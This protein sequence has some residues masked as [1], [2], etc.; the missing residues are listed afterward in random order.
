MESRLDAD[1]DVVVVG[2]GV[3]GL[4]AARALV[5]AGATVVVVEA[6]DRVG[7]RLKSVEAGG[8]VG[9][10]LGA[11][12]F[13]PGEARVERLVD[14]FSLEV[15][16]QHL[17][18]DA[19][20]HQPG[21]MTRIDGNPIDVPAGRFVRG[22]VAVTDALARSLPPGVV[23]C[24]HPV[25]AVRVIDG[26]DRLEV[27]S[28]D[29]AW[30]ACHVILALAP[31]LAAATIEFDPPLPASLDGLARSTPVWMGAMTKVVVTYRAPF[32]R[33]AGLAGAGISHLGPL[34]E[35]HDMSGPDGRPAALF[36]F[37]PS[38]ALRPGAGGRAA[39]VD[40]LVRMFGPPA[41]DPTEVIIADWSAEP[42]TSPPAVE[43][44]TDYRTYGHPDFA[45]PALGGRLHWSS[46]ETSTHSPG[47]IE[48][49]LAGAERAVAAVHRLDRGHTR[50]VNRQ[51]NP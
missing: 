3:S 29:R 46:T 14:E 51:E 13:W 5:Q 6:R 31:A 26:G 17:D 18:G 2:A 19:V 1:V 50:T 22:A 41:G 24:G 16:A 34:R 20:V 8:G 4:A 36:G 38:P 32:W 12:W 23:I 33:S 10:D 45:R 11:T 21:G 30:S 28:G 7:G 43:R 15:F 25:T 37:A 44:L 48:G 40:Q 27:R 49:A 47:H 42:F 35:V 39:V 9:L